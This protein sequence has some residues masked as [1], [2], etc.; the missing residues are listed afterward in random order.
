M[1]KMFVVIIPLL[2]SS[3]IFAQTEK[4]NLELSIS[5]SFGSFSQT[6]KS[7]DYTYEG[8]S[9]LYLTTSLRVGYYFLDS[10]QFEPELFVYYSE[11]NQPMYNING[12]FAYN[13]NIPESSI[14]P[15]V[16][17]GYGLGNSYPFLPSSGAFIRVKNDFNIGCFNAG[18]GIKVFVNKSVAIRIE[19]RYQ[20]YDDKEQ[21]NW[22][23]NNYNNEV[24]LNIH[25]VLFG[26]SFIL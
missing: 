17:L 14:K 19:Y 26:V 18:A 9:R 20:R 22:N 2:F 10:F 3:P 21:D 13:Y 5:G 15:F 1:K 4:G 11:N 25:K 12:N 24:I 6:S 16:L 23:G 7:N 8:E